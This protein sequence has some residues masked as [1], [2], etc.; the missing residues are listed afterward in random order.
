M[1]LK[2]AEELRQLWGEAPCDHPQLVKLYDKGERTGNYACAQCGK[3]FSFREKAE[4]Q[5]S[6]GE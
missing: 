1:K 3:V 4:L 2:R 5:A 6:R